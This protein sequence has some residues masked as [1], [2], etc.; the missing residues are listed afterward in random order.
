MVPKSGFTLIE[1]ILTLLIFSGLVAIGAFQ[2]KDYQRQTEEKL[3]LKKFEAKWNQMLTTAY[4]KN[5]PC[6]ANFDEDSITFEYGDKLK[7]MM[8]LP[9]TLVNKS[10]NDIRINSDAQTGPQSIR[11]YTDNLTKK[12]FYTVQMNWGVLVAKDP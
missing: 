6:R 9:G 12:H 1:A 7:T 3:A 10:K 11:F 8:M 2:I 5:I 4:L